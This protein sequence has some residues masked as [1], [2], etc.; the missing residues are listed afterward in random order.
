[1]YGAPGFDGRSGLVGSTD[2]K[3]TDGSVRM[4]RA[5]TDQK[6]EIGRVVSATPDGS[7]IAVAGKNVVRVYH[8]VNSTA[9]WLQVGSDIDDA[10]LLHRVLSSWVVDSISL[11]SSPNGGLVVAVAT[12]GILSERNG[13]ITTLQI[14]DA[15]NS[16]GWTVKG[17]RLDVGDVVVVRVSLI[18]GGNFLV[19]G[20]GGPQSNRYSD[21]LQFYRYEDNKWVSIDVFGGRR[22]ANDREGFRTMAVS[23]DNSILAFLV[24]SE[25]R[26]W[27]IGDF[28]NPN[29]VISRKFVGDKESVIAL[30]ERFAHLTSGFDVSLS[31]DGGI[32]AFGRN[33]RGGANVTVYAYSGP[34]S[35][36]GTWS[37]LGDDIEYTEIYY[38]GPDDPSLF[39]RQNATAC[40]SSLSLSLS[41]DGNVV[42]IG[43][44][45]RSA[46][47]GTVE[48]YEYEWFR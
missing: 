41:G 32:L 4:I 6:E 33:D 40:T 28:Q 9:G 29:I 37:R 39:F 34:P 25:I 48:V 24:G 8:N 27:R 36:P 47:R 38:R 2:W 5:A 17:N 30:D 43:N 12:R 11:A 14:G 16:T 7:F 3:D 1:V 42:V 26:V 15:T 23:R 21:M 13:E 19:V 20:E 35:S 18:F 22:L 31:H 45:C 10:I 46:N 44:P